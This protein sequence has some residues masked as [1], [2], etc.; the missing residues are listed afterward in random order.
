MIVQDDDDCLFLFHYRDE[1]LY[2][3][4]FFFIT[5]CK[6]Q[7]IKRFPFNRKKKKIQLK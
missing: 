7:Q 3:F 6:L 1:K 2:T 5:T 4:M